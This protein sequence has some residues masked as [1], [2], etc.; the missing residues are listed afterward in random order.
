MTPV[1]FSGQ[2]F[3][4]EQSENSLGDIRVLWYDLR[5]SSSLKLAQAAVRATSYKVIRE[6]LVDAWRQGQKEKIMFPIEWMRVF[7]VSA[8]LVAILLTGVQAAPVISWTDPGGGAY[9]DG[10]N[11]NGGGGIP[12]SGNGA[13]FGQDAIYTVTFSQNEV[14]DHAYVRYGEVTFDLNSHTYSLTYP[15]TPPP[16][17]TLGD[18]TGTDMKLT[19]LD[20]RLNVAR[21]KMATVG[22]SGATLEIG[23]GGSVGN[24]ATMYV[25]IEG[26]AELRIIDGGKLLKRSNMFT[27]ATLGENDGSLGIMTVQ[28]IGSNWESSG[29]VYVG[30]SGRGNL[31]ISGGATATSHRDGFRVAVYAGGQGTMTIDGQGTSLTLLGQPSKGIG[32]GNLDVGCNGPGT[33]TISGG[34]SSTGA[35][36]LKIGLSYDSA[37]GARGDGT[38]TVTGNGSTLSTKGSRIGDRGD[39]VLNILDGAT[40]SH[41]GSGYMGSYPGSTAEVTVSGSGSTWT[42][43]GFYSMLYMGRDYSGN[44]GG[45]A[46]LTVTNG[47]Q[48]EVEDLFLGPDAVVTTDSLT[49]G[50]PP[51][52]SPGVA[53]G[54]A[55]AAEPG[56]LFVQ[57][58]T[59]ADGAQV[60]AGSLHV[61]AG[62]QIHGTGGVS[63]DVVN[64]GVIGPG[65]TF[66]PFAAA[67][68]AIG[69]LD[70][71]G[72]YDQTAGSTLQIDLDANAAGATCDLLQATDLAQLDG[73]LELRLFGNYTPIAGD[74]FTV[75]T[76]AGGVDGEFADVTFTAL[77]GTDLFADV[78]YSDTAV[79]VH[80]MPEPASI[81][82]LLGAVALFPRRMRRRRP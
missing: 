82:L 59:L 38:V 9:R 70:V 21:V 3:I 78:V 39:G 57:T 4:A 72:N 81:C 45:H 30:A 68:P 1:F 7:L 35:S 46:E 15:H 40:V 43:T 12:G 44:P 25:G 41:D 6:I 76:A 32:P 29:R 26:Q 71:S 51:A 63:G 8:A 48:V 52:L 60:D 37:T 80:I 16:S 20:G 73:L 34:A 61:N 5:C 17:L 56:G 74:R 67:T 36:S 14:N 18:V 53:L 42:M 19:V 49:I 31:S 66:N 77:D 2:R 58:L 27:G 62:G 13:F 10:A 24:A 79:G 64:D 55:P 69:L 75:L 65:D 11:W 23:Q 54:A 28:G 50:P 33:L 47:G 22:A